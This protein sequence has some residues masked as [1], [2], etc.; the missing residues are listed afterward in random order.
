MAIYLL[1]FVLSGKQIKAL[2]LAGIRVLERL[3]VVGLL[4]TR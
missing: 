1:S 4:P 2:A 3:G